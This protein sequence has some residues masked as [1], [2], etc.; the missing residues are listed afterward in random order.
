MKNKVT[1]NKI[2]SP[3][4]QTQ[5]DKIAYVLAL[6]PVDIICPDGSFPDVQIID[7]RRLPRSYNL[8]VY[9]LKGWE[10]DSREYIGHHPTDL[11]RHSFSQRDRFMHMT[12]RGEKRNQSYSFELHFWPHV[13]LL[14]NGDYELVK[15]PL[16]E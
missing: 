11:V 5:R 7:R 2:G 13:R 4:L 9:T 12:L 1:F 15:L 8:G 3:R 6:C 16:K 14:P 10:F